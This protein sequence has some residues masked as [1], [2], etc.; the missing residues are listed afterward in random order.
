MIVND[1]A[2]WSTCE[3]RMVEGARRGGSEGWVP[4]RRMTSTIFG[5]VESRDLLDFLVRPPVRAITSTSC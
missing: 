5:S 1:D 2:S 4:T 3:T